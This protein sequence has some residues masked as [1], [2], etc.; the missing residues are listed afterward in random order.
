[1]PPPRL[2]L[3]GIDTLECAYYLRQKAITTSDT[4]NFQELIARREEL[5]RAKTKEAA[6]VTLG[7]VDCL[8]HPYGSGSGYPIVIS[9][10]DFHIQMGEFNDP[11]F[12]VRFRS[13]ALW[14]E[15]ALALHAKFLEWTRAVGLGEYKSEGLS[16]VDWSFD[17]LLPEIDFDD[18]NF[19]SLS[20]KDSRHREDR[21]TQTFSF[22]KGDVMLRVY[23]KI[24]EIAQQSDKVWFFELW[25]ETENVW[26]V[27]WQAR[28]A[29]LRR[30]GIRSFQSLKELQG[31][32]LRYLATEH[33][34]LRIKQEDSN[35]SRWPLHPLWI[36]IQS[37]IS[38]MDCLGVHR[39]I[40]PGWSL[41]ARL[42]R[43]AM[44]MHGNLKRIAAIERLKRGSESVSLKESL[45]VLERK[46]RGIHDRCTWQIDI[47]KRVDEMR[48]GSW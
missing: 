6:V 33:D 21:K 19:V 17:Y 36:D 16:R 39:V 38:A 31:D 23:D 3:Q 5:R 12:F 25:G 24:A 27:E 22:G 18:D 44:S 4:L 14:R 37:Q 2:L 34:T 32:A 40:D 9:N 46:M 43:I 41:D 15:S 35:R 48:L 10:Q 8:L 30:F 28:K 47:D 42:F 20:T 1:M 26:R 13:E 29:L 11:S 45:A 7:G